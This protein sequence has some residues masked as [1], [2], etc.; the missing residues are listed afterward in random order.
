[1]QKQ[2]EEPV[3]PEEFTIQL[4]KGGTLRVMSPR[5]RLSNPADVR[6]FEMEVE[7]I[8]PTKMDGG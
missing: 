4:S 2:H 8:P 7:E 6:L 5:L 1:M 3:D